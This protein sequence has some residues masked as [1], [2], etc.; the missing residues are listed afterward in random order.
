MGVTSRVKTM[1]APC[2]SPIKL[3]VSCEGASLTALGGVV[4]LFELLAAKRILVGLPRS[5][6]SPAQGWSDAQMILAVPVLDVAGFDRVS[7]IEHLETDAGPCALL[8]RFEP[9]LPGMS[10]RAIARRFRGGSAARLA[11]PFPYGGRA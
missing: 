10:R 1:V 8:K 9:K 2:R 3:E 5:V 7:D 11:G 4:L 6:G